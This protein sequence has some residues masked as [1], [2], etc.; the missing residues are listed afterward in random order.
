[1]V[2]ILLIESENI[3]YGDYD[4][5]QL[6]TIKEISSMEELVKKFGNDIAQSVLALNALLGN[7]QIVKAL[8][9]YDFRQTS[10]LINISDRIKA[11][12]RYY[13]YGDKYGSHS[14]FKELDMTNIKTIDIE[15]LAHPYTIL[16]QSIDKSSIKDINKNVWNRLETKRKVIE[17][18]NKLKAVKSKERV[19]RKKQKEIEKAKK[20]LEGLKNE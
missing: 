10:K 16:L 3:H 12:Q 2:K 6:I 13:S 4:D 5:E 20:L 8:D 7:E 19:E 14:S 9:R 17:N 1:M 18:E 15:N 11:E